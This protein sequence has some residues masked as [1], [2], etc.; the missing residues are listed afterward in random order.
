[1]TS[2]AFSDRIL[3][4]LARKDYHPRKIR[5][6]A[7]AM[8]IA[9][10]EYGDFR[11]AVKGL[12]RAGRV[13]LGSGNAVLLPEMG[14]EF[15]GRFRSNPRGFG[16]IIP[17]SPTA[18]GD[19]FVP[20]GNA[21][22][23]ITGDLVAATVL[24][25]GH[26]G[27]KMIHEGRIVRIIERGQS[28][29]VG[30][31]QYE[32]GRWFVRAD[33]NI[34]HAPIV[35]G[36]PTAKGAKAGD[37]VVVEVTRYP[38]GDREAL[39]VIVRVLG[40]AGEPEVD[41]ASIIVQYQL[42]HEFDDEALGDAR[43]A[44]ADYDA[45]AV[46]RD[47]EDL[48]DLTIITIDPDDARDFDD[49]ISL[50]V[51]PRGRF[52]LGVHIADVSHFVR[53][54]TALDRT[55]RERGTSV[56]F[57]RHVVPMLPELISNGLCSL[58]EGEPRLTKSAFITYDAKGKVVSE[59]V[60]NSIIRSAK[61]LTYL[62]ASAALDGKTG[63]LPAA[64]VELLR[65][66][67]KLARVIQQRRQ[68]EGMIE[69]DLPEV[70]L[71]MDDAGRVT[72]V[73]PTDNSYSHKIIEMFMVEANETVARLFAGLNVPCLRRVH[74][75]PDST[76]SRDLS[77]FL[78]M[79]DLP[80]PSLDDRAGLRALLKQV[81]GTPQSFAVNLAVLRSMQRAVYSP[82]LEGHYALASE[83]YA[84]FTSPIRR[85]PDL[86]V[87]RLV[88]RFARGEFQKQDRHASRRPPHPT[89]SPKEGEGKNKRAGV[90]AIDSSPMDPDGF[91]A[92]ERLGVHC[93]Q[94]ERQA[95]AAERELRQVKVLRLM[96][97]RVGQ[98]VDGVVTGV[99]NFGVF[100]QLT[101]FL[102]DGLLGFDN[103]A[104]DWWEVDSA[105]GCVRGQRTG[106]RIAIGEPLRVIIDAVD[107]PTRRL[108]LA[109]PRGADGQRPAGG[110]TK[111]SSRGAG[112]ADKPRRG[113]SGRGQSEPR[114]AEAVT[115]RDTP[116]VRKSIRP[117]RGRPKTGRSSTRGKRRGR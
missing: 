99:A 97:T 76:V 9:E 37:Q 27:G 71:V 87:H 115:P 18:H 10:D 90:L 29:F 62:Q 2:D 85:Y 54:G 1:M 45:D 101:E 105:R 48:R 60:A 13:V 47:R 24:K 104:D 33:G 93:S 116:G 7:T 107:I 35:I 6:L 80:T 43:R 109:M 36:D 65:V 38:D 31:L 66:M 103:I 81:H 42:P 49:A 16:F 32:F 75:D 26:R 108:D 77:K 4:F 69:L 56:Y 61:R 5:P 113:R 79:L 58:Q 117:N 50:Q 86:T 74:P 20:P 14:G 59:R 110:R 41:T 82:V 100:V 63:D 98:A 92:F 22:G 46:A 95:E 39:G 53:E 78:N 34:M 94:R 51:R 91:E 67:E 19:L 106:R 102:I 8:G 55:A 21:G 70:D 96:E 84:H 23:A 57:P 15:I 25:K 111:P 3:K 89:L 64:V 52:E 68:R 88:D 11:H 114:K 72:G 40:P 30:A 83:H 112:G 73:K 12:A 28:Q 44:V 17:E